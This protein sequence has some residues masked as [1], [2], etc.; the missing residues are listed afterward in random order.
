MLK[1]VIN[2]LSRFF[3]ESFT[4]EIV[5]VS[6]NNVVFSR[7]ELVFPAEKFTMPERL[8]IF[9]QNHYYF[10]GYT[11]DIPPFYV[12]SIEN[13]KCVVGREE[14]FIS[15]NEVIIEHTPHSVNPWLGKHNWKLQNPLKVNGSVANLALSTIENNYYH[16]LTE[17]LGH[18]YLLERSQFKP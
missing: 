6:I 14:I 10:A 16:W 8:D 1:R 13:A 12:R 7:E 18:Y 5:G 9:G 2:K 3:E 11:C 17:C 15:N 4:P